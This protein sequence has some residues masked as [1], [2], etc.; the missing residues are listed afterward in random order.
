[1]RKDEVPPKIREAIEKIEPI[2]PYAIEILQLIEDEDSS[3]LDIA[4]KVSIDPVISL[5]LLKACSSAAIGIN[6]QSPFQAVAV[7]GLKRVVEIILTTSIKKSIGQVVATYDFD[8]W[9]HNLMV[10]YT[11]QALIREKSYPISLAKGFTA[12]ILHDVGK[13]ILIKSSGETSPLISSQMEFKCDSDIIEKERQIY[14]LS[15]VDV[16]AYL[17]SNWN[18]PEEI[19]TAILLHHND[20]RELR[21]L[22]RLISISHYLIRLPDLSVDERDFLMEI[23]NLEMSTLENIYDW[24]KREMELV[25]FYFE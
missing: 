7:L 14:G 4:R 18:L 22:A 24:V 15:H 8:L 21:G 11:V 2:S 19:K 6:V 5:Q 16:M 25:N 9:E 1:M 3:L 10:A 13:K 20:I 23:I 12:G 17:F